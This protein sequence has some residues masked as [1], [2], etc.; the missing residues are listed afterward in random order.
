MLTLLP[1]SS[2]SLIRCTLGKTNLIGPA[3]YA[4][5]SYCWGDPNDTVEILVNDVPTPVT[6]NL[7]DA[8]RGLQSIGVIR[9]W[10]DALCINQ[11]DGQ[12]KSQ[13]IRNMTQIY[14]RAIKT[15]A[16]IG[17][18]ADDQSAVVMD[19]MQWILLA[20]D[21]ALQEM[22]YHT[23]AITPRS[24]VHQPLQNLGYTAML[25]MQP[26]ALITCHITEPETCRRCL[27]D[28][29]FDVLMRF[30]SR[31]YWKRQ[32]IIQEIAVAC[33]VILLWGGMTVCLE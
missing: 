24:R 11:A 19:F 30:F 8:L 18:D 17:I 21:D 1:E 15:Y 28:L 6:A 14:S 25:M 20:P 10:A 26:S 13:Q 32:W 23:H 16:W 29:H 3:E 2:K 4:A 12:E 27:R 9:V 5:L 7:A 22:L 31:D 33:Q